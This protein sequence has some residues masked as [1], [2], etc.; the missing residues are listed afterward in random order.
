MPLNTPL[1]NIRRSGMCVTVISETHQLDETDT[2]KPNFIPFLDTT[3]SFQDLSFPE[4]LDL[5][6]ESPNNSTPFTTQLPKCLQ[7]PHLQNTEPETGAEYNIEPDTNIQ[8]LGPK[9]TNTDERSDT[10]NPTKIFI[11]QTSESLMVQEIDFQDEL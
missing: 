10:T 11:G 2:D 7:A 5:I 8:N 3:I 6:F 9:E 4:E 1:E